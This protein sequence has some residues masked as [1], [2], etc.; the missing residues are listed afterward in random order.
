[1]LQRLLPIF[2]VASVVSAFAVAETADEVPAT[3]NAFACHD[4]EDHQ[5]SLQSSLAAAINIRVERSWET[6]IQGEI[7]HKAYTETGYG[8]GAIID[9]T[10]GLVITNAHVV[11]GQHDTLTVKTYDMHSFDDPTHNYSAH[12]IGV[13]YAS[14]VAVLQL[15]QFHSKTLPCFTLNKESPAVGD[16]TYSIGSPLGYEF[17]MKVGKI[18]SPPEDLNPSELYSNAKTSVG[19]SGSITVNSFGEFSGLLRGLLGKSGSISGDHA[20]IIPP[21]VVVESVNNILLSKPN[22]QLTMN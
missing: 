18:I 3:E 12:I 8:S 21:N 19:D 13:D 4:A 15:N 9:N 2:C 6:G 16:M 11:D 14:D 20:V 1:M 22:A 10:R 17:T 7:G 5:I